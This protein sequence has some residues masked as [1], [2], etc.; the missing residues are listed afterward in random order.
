SVHH[1]FKNVS[2]AP[3][4]RPAWYYD[5]DQLGNGLVDVTT[6]LVDL[7]QWTCF[8][9]QVLDYQKDI[10]MTEAKRWA[11]LITPS[12]FKKSTNKDSYPEF[13]KKDVKDS[14]LSVYSNGE[15]N[16]TIKGVSAKVSVIWNYQAPEGTGDT[17]FS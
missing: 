10:K 1:F 16:Y 11:T 15:M 13:L 5:V 6:H 17:H 2:G 8:P 3:L 7:I 9:E 14:I 4:I 12:Q